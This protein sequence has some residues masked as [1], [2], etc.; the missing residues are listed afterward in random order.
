MSKAHSKTAE[1]QRPTDSLFY[2]H[3]CGRWARKIR[4][5]LNEFGQG[6]HADALALHESR[7]DELHGGKVRRDDNAGL[8][9]H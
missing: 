1:P 6:R 8:T 9:V 2:W 5:G 3:A 7:K 4:G